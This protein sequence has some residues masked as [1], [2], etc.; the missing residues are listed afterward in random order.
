MAAD[1]EMAWFLRTWD[2]ERPGHR[3]PGDREGGLGPE[4]RGDPLRVGVSRL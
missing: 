1:G 4:G 3:L 2:E